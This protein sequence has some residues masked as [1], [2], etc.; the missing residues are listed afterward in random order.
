M[1]Q[2][3]ITHHQ[4]DWGAKLPLSEDAR[5]GR[6]YRRMSGGVKLVSLILT[7]A[8]IIGTGYAYY[9]LMHTTFGVLVIPLGLVIGFAFAAW[10][11]HRYD[12]LR[13]L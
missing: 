7:F 10:L 5:R 11:Y 13:E 9:F 8:I 4:P 1:T 2:R 12:D 3:D 6:P